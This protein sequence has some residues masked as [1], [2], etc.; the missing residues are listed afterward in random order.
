MRIVSQDGQYDLPYDSSIV[1]RDGS[2][3]IAGVIGEDTQIVMAEYPDEK[4]A[5]DE[6]RSMHKSYGLMLTGV[7][8]FSAPKR[9][10]RALDE[11]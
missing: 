9:H 5:I 3:I 4:S 1:V 2:N 11:V 7:F 8:V 10:I 6:L